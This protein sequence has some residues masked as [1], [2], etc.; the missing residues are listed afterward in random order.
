L[1]FTLD[2]HWFMN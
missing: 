1:T 2:Y